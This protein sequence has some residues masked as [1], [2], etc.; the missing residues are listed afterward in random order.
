M[1]GSA[2]TRSKKLPLPNGSIVGER[3]EALSLD[4]IVRTT[5][6]VHFV[7]P[8]LPAASPRAEPGI[9]SFG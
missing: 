1:P 9:G 8:G 3:V 2:D 6:I 4:H 5:H 7:I